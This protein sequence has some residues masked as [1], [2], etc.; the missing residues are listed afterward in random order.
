[1]DRSAIIIGCGPAGLACA[2]SL[3]AVGLDAV[4]L[5]QA[6]NVG[7]VWRRH[8]DRLH[9][10]TDRRHSGLPGRPMPRSLPKY[11]SREQFVGY[12][13]SYAAYFRIEPVFNRR[14]TEISRSGSLWRVTTDREVYT[15]A[16]V[17]IATGLAGTPCEPS[18]PGLNGF[19]GSRI[20]SSAY[21]NPSGYSGKRVLVVGFGNSGGEIALDLANAGI[22]VTLAVRSPVQV[23]PRDLL[24]FPILTWAIAQ[25]HFPARAVDLINAP[26]IRLAVGSF[27]GTGLRRARK[28][29][30]QMIEQ[31]GRIPV[32][33]IG[34]IARIRNGSIKVQGAVR[35][36]TPDGVVFSDDS[37]AKF[38]AVILATGF[39][40]NVRELL[41]SV[42]G[43][44]DDQGKPMVSGR[45][46]GAPGLYFCG[47]EPSATGQLRQIGL[48]ARRLA[49]LA[50]A[51]LAI[52]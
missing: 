46:T 33:D 5:E 45:Q 3:K 20:H 12:L 27:E 4:V 11:P 43:V 1:M 22:D 44:L 2:A 23:L 10:H 6:G 31:D 26:I 35:H 21:R 32:L 24:G 49:S 17:V 30:R 40:P 16:V 41:P 9:L 51:Y 42:A 25:Q 38:D 48:E 29:P 19:G 7:S 37:A 36:F 39:R 52:A 18:W 34:T 28:G 47:Y 8:Y 15:A 14:A 50:Q 13:D